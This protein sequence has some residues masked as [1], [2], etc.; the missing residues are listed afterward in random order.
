MIWTSWT[1]F[2]MHLYCYISNY[3]EKQY[4]EVYHTLWYIVR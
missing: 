4:I 3:Q 1:R 2:F